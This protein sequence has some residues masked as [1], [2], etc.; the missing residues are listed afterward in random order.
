MDSNYLGFSLS[1]FAKN[2]VAQKTGFPF[3]AKIPLLHHFLSKNCYTA[4]HPHT[5]G[6][7]LSSFCI[8]SN[9]WDAILFGYPF[10]ID[11]HFRAPKIWF[12]VD[13]N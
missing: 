13:R 12:L 4:C 2:M 7:Y 5:L 11:S 9:N 1:G 6:V 3:R 10:N 8:P